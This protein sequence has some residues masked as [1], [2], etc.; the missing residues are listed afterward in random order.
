[1]PAG[2]PARL[3]ANS[4]RSLSRAIHILG[5]IRNRPRQIIPEEVYYDLCA[6]F[7]ARKGED[8]Q[9][10]DV[11]IHTDKVQRIT[12]AGRAGETFFTQPPALRRLLG[13][14]LTTATSFDELQKSWI[15]QRVKMKA[16]SELHSKKP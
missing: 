14:L 16:L 8:P 15:V 10:F 5:E 3:G 12:E 1:M 13:S 6:L 11:S 4:D 9:T 7:V 2:C